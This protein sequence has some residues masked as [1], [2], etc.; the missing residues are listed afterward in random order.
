[1]VAIRKRVLTE[2]ELELYTRTTKGAAIILNELMSGINLPT[3][4][5]IFKGISIHND[6]GSGIIVEILSPDGTPCLSLNICV[7]MYLESKSRTL[8]KSDTTEYTAP[9][10]N[11]LL[12]P[13]LIP[14]RLLR[15]VKLL[16]KHVNGE[17]MSIDGTTVQVLRFNSHGRQYMITLAVDKAYVSK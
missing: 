14:T 16:A 11:K 13:S 12:V 4:R 15:N 3:Y 6:T 8:S 17:V 2:E 5:H 10:S 7:D 9:Y 1:M